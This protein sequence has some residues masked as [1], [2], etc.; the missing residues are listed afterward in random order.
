MVFTYVCSV[1]T[2]P[3]AGQR[4]LLTRN[5][6]HTYWRRLLKEAGITGL[7]FHDLRHDF[8]T[9]AATLVGQSQAGAARA[10]NHRDIKTTLKYAHVLD[11]EVAAAMEHVAESR[12]KSRTRLRE[13]G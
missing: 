8:G 10:M 2:W 13:I 7:R 1:R 12:K 9:T 11:S 4:L 6:L 5:G 3:S